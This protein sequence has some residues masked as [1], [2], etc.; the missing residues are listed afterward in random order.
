MVT[1]VT[2]HI[3]R[4][5]ISNLNPQCADT[6]KKGADLASSNKNQFFFHVSLSIFLYNISPSVKKASC[7]TIMSLKISNHMFSLFVKGKYLC[8]LLT[9]ESGA[10][11]HPQITFS[12]LVLDDH[13]VSSQVLLIHMQAVWL[14]CMYCL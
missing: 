6:S 7:F 9:F 8:N 14:L 11:I 13:N 10:I 4:R 5:T 12:K 3:Y 1:D 2:M